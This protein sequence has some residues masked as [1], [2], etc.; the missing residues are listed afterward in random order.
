MKL[1]TGLK[2]ENN[3]E[4]MQHHLKGSIKHTAWQLQEANF[5]TVA[6]Y[7]YI[8]KTLTF[9]ICMVDTRRLLEEVPFFRM[10]KKG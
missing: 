10:T 9:M 3:I 6:N 1:K 2:L 5:V 4:V 8:L 7:I